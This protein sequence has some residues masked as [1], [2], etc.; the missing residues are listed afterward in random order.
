M[1]PRGWF[2]RAWML[3]NLAGLILFLFV[4]SHFWIEPELEGMPGASVG[5]A[6]GWAVFAFPLFA[7]FMIAHVAKLVWLVRNPRG[8]PRRRYVAL[9]VTLACWFAAYAYDN[10]HHGI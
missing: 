1:M 5:A 4:A 2:T 7:S 6:F 9:A 3:A 10:M 8:R